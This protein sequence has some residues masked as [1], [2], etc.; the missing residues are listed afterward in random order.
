MPSIENRLTGESFRVDISSVSITELKAILKKNGWKFNW[1]EEYKKPNH[2]IF[3]ISIADDTA[4]IQGLVSIQINS[5]HVYMH[6]VES[7]PLNRGAGK[8]Y[9]GVMECLVAY[10]CM[11]SFKEGYEGNVAFMAKTNLIG[12]YMEKLG[13]IHIGGGRMIITSEKAALLINEHL[14]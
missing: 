11:I 2:Q 3:K 9:L 8:L 4:V 14:V 7:A 12:H 10:V 1:Q 5:D 13:A 6:L